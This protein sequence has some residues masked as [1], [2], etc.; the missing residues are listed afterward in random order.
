MYIFL[1][2][3]ENAA[4]NGVLLFHV[5]FVCIEIYIEFGLG[6]RD[7]LRARETVKMSRLD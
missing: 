6:Y 2:L 3:K 7:L 1:S 5:N 4:H